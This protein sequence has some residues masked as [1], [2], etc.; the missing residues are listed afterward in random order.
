MKEFTIVRKGYSPEEVDA[1]ITELES[2]LSVKSQ[3]VK[4]F[5]AK[6]SAINASLVNAELCAQYVR[7][8]AEADAAEVHNNALKEM[9]G[10]REQVLA[11]HGKLEEFQSEF[12]RVLQE[13]LVS[14]RTN[15]LVEI[16]SRTEKF[17][18]SLTPNTESEQADIPPEYEFLQMK[19]EPE[20][21][22][23]LEFM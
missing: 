22:A 11:L 8:Q 2:A 6:E 16:F 14:L 12:G 21:E 20:E 23:P 5:Q 4:E 15:D 9:D 13:H 19:D 10:L 18:D 7:A 17:I 1:Y 3:M